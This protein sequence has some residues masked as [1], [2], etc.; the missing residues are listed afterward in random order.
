M[1]HLE[2]LCA[3]G[4]Q[5]APP[6]PGFAFHRNEIDLLNF[7]DFCREKNAVVQGCGA[8]LEIVIRI[9]KINLDIVLTWY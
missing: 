2:E 1:E 3:T 6:C 5:N 7:R 4:I 8:P 9:D